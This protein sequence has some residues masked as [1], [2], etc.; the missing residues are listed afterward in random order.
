MS[1]WYSSKRPY[2][3]KPREM[4][5]ASIKVSFV[6]KGE[7]TKRIPNDA[8]R[9]AVQQCY[10]NVSHTQSSPGKTGYAATRRIPEHLV[11]L[12]TRQAIQTVILVEQEHVACK[13][14]HVSRLEPPATLPSGMTGERHRCEGAAASET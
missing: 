4:Q 8:N 7:K 2:D 14:H 10:G 9:L 5:G 12:C 3:L 11:E 1:K 6:I 13:S